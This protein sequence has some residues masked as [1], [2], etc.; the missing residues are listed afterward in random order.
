MSERCCLVEPATAR[1]RCCLVEPA[2]A[3][4]RCC[5]VEEAIEVLWLL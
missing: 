3:R 1:E 2:T 5:L 4:E